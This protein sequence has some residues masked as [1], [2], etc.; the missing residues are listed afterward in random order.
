MG[1]KALADQV[2]ILASLNALPYQHTAA[3]QLLSAKSIDGVAASVRA[4]SGMVQTLTPKKER[5]LQ[6]VAESYAMMAGLTDTIVKESGVSFREAHDVVAHIVVDNYT[7]GRPATAI[8]AN[9]V[10]STAQKVLGRELRLNAKTVNEALDPVGNVLGLTVIGGPAPDQ[11]EKH[12][13]QVAGEI[14]D[15][16]GRLKT[17][18]EAI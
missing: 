10:N 6:N 15:A 16:A 1:A 4:M 11:V 13:K 17:R 9:V 8:N 18:R 5:M 14:E 12:I 2:G 7:A 3:R